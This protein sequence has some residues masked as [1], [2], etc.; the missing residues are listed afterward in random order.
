[1]SSQ[2]DELRAVCSELARRSPSREIFS[3]AA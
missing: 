2:D 3:E 1:M